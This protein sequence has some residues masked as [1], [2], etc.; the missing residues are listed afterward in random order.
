LFDNHWVYDP[1]E[2]RVV[3]SVYKNLIEL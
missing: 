3:K 1:K 2:K